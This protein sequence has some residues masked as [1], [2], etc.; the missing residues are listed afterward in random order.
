V[1]HGPPDD[2]YAVVDNQLRVYGIAGLR[3]VDVSVF[4]R[5]TSGT[6]NAP[7]I[8]VAERAADLVKAYWHAVHLG[9]DPAEYVDKHVLHSGG[10]YQYD[11]KLVD[12]QVAEPVDNQDFANRIAVEL[13]GDP[14]EVRAKQT[15]GKTTK[16]GRLESVTGE[17]N[18]LGSHEG[19]AKELGDGL[20]FSGDKEDLNEFR[21]DMV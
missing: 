5:I 10:V 16:E 21:Y 12:A 4:P 13:E 17:A 1:C 8:M 20:R 15:V 19:N 7:V 14:T 3:V 18:L 6:N 2:H 11:G 9:V